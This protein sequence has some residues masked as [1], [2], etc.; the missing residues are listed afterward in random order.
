MLCGFD[1][2]ILLSSALTL[3]LVLLTYLLYK[4]LSVFSEGTYRRFILFIYLSVL[5][6]K[7]FG[8]YYIVPYWD[9]ILHFISGIISARIGAEIFNKFNKPD[10]NHRVKTLFVILFTVSVA[11]IWEIWEFSGDAVFGLNAQ[12]GSLKDTMFDIIAGISGGLI[13]IFENRL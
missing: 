10:K 4:K 6:G 13:R 11:T 3:F 5:L 12:N 7:V 8:F 1:T 9:K 2:N